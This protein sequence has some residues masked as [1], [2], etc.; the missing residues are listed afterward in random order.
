MRATDIPEI[1]ARDLVPGAPGRA[2]A[3]AD[4]ARAARVSGF[5]TVH[6]TA[7]DAEEIAG[8]LVEL[9]AFFHAPE[10]E[11]SR[12]DMAATGSNRGWGAPLGERVDPG[13]N[14]DYKEVFD[15]GFELAPG[16]PLAAR[17]LRYY[18]PNR[19]PEGRPR[20]RA[21][22]ERYYARTMGVS[23]T[24]LR[25]L[26]EAL[27]APRDHFD[28]RFDRPMALLRGNFYP[29]RPPWAG[30]RDFGI[31]PHTDYGCLTLLAGDGV[32]GLE[33]QGRAGDWRPVTSRPGA[34]VVN[35][36]EMLEIW[37]AGE[38][39]A[40]PHRVIGSEAER[41]S[42]PLFFNPDYDTDIS[43]PGSVTPRLAG[44]HLSRR[45]DETY[46]HLDPTA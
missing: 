13:S 15:M 2:A 32:P 29:A 39:R 19:W 37:T 34:F 14:P 36:G 24:L 11:K 18:A 43:P 33:V 16:D 17:G 40:T 3:L 27:G 30:E 28:G 8:V 22:L 26:A 35:F 23:M 1:D 31:A 44:E 7:I 10:A 38:V 45:F 21:T 25:A 20:F 42:L 4:L 46:L 41:I 9:R 12:I 6:S 5:F